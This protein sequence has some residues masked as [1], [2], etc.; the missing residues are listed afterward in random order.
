MN[1]TQPLPESWSWLADFRPYS[2]Q[3]AIS[4]IAFILIGVALVRYGLML[5]RRDPRLE[6]RLR[7]GW[8]W[9][10]LAVQAI[11]TT[12]WLLPAHFTPAKS[13]PLALC[14]LAAWTTGIYF[15]TRA[16]PLRALVYYWGL[17]L[18]SQAFATPILHEGEGIATVR[19][20]FFYIVHMNIVFGAIYD[21]VVGGYRPTW[22]DFWR[23][24]VITMAYLALVLPINIGLDVNYGF[25]GASDRQPGIVAMLPQ[26]PWRVYG[27]MAGGFIAFVLATLPWMI[28]GRLRTPGAV[29]EAHAASRVTGA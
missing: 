15:V 7:L 27:V 3:H 5:R 11:E 25:V 23:A 2:L 29:A 18:S 12:W 28:A 21:L 6:S 24:I 16:R 14:D 26:W 1:Q 17:C 20:W 8:G 4:S 22:S 9:F 13:F 10:I 19:F